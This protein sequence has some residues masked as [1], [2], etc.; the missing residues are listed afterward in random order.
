MK[1]QGI[2]S[3]VLKFLEAAGFIT[4][5]VISANKAGILDIIACE[6]TG[7]YW[8]IEARTPTGRAS[9]LQ[10]RRVKQ[11]LANGGVSFI[12]YGYNDF[13]VKFNNAT[14]VKTNSNIALVD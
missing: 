10:E 8:E 9:K 4:C 7:R 11:V 2:Q 1:E 14:V 3:K 12:F 6:R 5:K 13:L